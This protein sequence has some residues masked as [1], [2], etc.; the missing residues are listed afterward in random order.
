VDLGL[1]TGLAAYGDDGRLRWYRSQHFGAAASLRRAVPSL[2]DGVSHLV[3]E[4]GGSLANAWSEE[5]ATRGI[6]VRW[7][8][9]ETWRATFLYPREQRSGERAKR[10]AED[11]AR[12]VI[13]WSGARRPTSLRHDAAEAI[14]VGLWGVLQLGWLASLPPGLVHAAS[15]AAGRGTRPGPPGR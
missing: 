2:L 4:G 9:A 15:T 1:R 13:E 14:L 5:A 3:I 10:S 8:S 6:E 7:V 12:R 11:L